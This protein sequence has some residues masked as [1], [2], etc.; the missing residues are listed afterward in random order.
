[1]FRYCTLAAIFVQYTILIRGGL[2]TPTSAEFVDMP[3]LTALA[4]VDG[5]KRQSAVLVLGV[6]LHLSE[7]LSHLQTLVLGGIA[8][9]T[10]L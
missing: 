10:L 1:M 6:G 7:P 9:T 8:S 3:A 5:V 2:A 4:G